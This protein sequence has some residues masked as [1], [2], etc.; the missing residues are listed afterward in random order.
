MYN[1]LVSNFMQMRNSGGDVRVLAQQLIMSNPQTQQMYEQMKNMSNGLS[2]KDFA[3]QYAKQN[4]V[5][6]EQLIQTARMIGINI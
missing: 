5:S 6:E 4:G 3:L 2:P 1:N